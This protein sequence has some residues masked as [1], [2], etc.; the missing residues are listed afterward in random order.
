V[1]ALT[2]RKWPDPVHRSSTQAENKREQPPKRDRQAFGLFNEEPAED[3][4]SGEAGKSHNQQKASLEIA[5][6]SINPGLA[7]YG[8]R[9]HVSLITF[10]RSQRF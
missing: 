9:P 10:H 6:A 5:N 8:G 2:G 3:S 1:L 7:I 4:G